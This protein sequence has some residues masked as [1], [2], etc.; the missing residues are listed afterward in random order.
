ML[1]PQKFESLMWEIQPH[2]TNDFVGQIEKHILDVKTPVKYLSL[3]VLAEANSDLVK[4]A[5]VS[6]AITQKKILF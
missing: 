1:S 5:K 4:S 2:L 3:L 6:N